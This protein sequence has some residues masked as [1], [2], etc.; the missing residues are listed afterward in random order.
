MPSGLCSNENLPYTN[1]K[2][3]ATDL[4]RHYKNTCNRYGEV[5]GLKTKKALHIFLLGYAPD[6]I[7]G[8]NNNEYGHG[9]IALTLDRLF[10]KCSLFLVPIEGG[11][12]V[13]VR[14]L[15]DYT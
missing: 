2:L 3:E 9:V 5:E 8:H 12:I 13:I 15:L 10:E 1:T 7:C 4:E 6:Q 11:G 14:I